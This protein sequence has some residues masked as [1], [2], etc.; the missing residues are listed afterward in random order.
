MLPRRELWGRRCVSLYAV[1]KT[2]GIF[3]TRQRRSVS[4][5]LAYL[6]TSGPA[7]STNT[8]QKRRVLVH[9][10]PPCCFL[11]Y[12]FFFFLLLGGRPGD[13]T[14]ETVAQGVSE[15]RDAARGL[16]PCSG[17]RSAGRSGSRFWVCSPDAAT[18]TGLQNLELPSPPAVVGRCQRTFQ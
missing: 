16:A 17:D 2:S 13:V 1:T 6:T 18:A 9:L 10:P 3:E 4:L 7:M 15:A 11:C 14:D 5:A 8:G 12:V